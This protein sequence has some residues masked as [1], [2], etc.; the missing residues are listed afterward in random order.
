[1]YLKNSIT[2]L[3]F[4]L[5]KKKVSFIALGG[6]LFNICAQNILRMLYLFGENTC[7]Y[8]SKKTKLGTQEII[9]L[10]LVEILHQTIKLLGWDL[11]AQI[12]SISDS[13]LIDRL[14]VCTISSDGFAWTQGLRMKFIEQWSSL[15]LAHTWSVR[16]VICAGQWLR[17]VLGSSVPLLSPCPSLGGRGA[18]EQQPHTGTCK[19]RT[20]LHLF[21]PLTLLSPKQ[22]S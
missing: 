6:E 18:G 21:A 9:F 4:T 22:L 13:G 8:Y 5:K 15:F 2:C 11:W 1:M 12:Q 14:L 10:S 20:I 3:L 19:R 16:W 7:I 17:W